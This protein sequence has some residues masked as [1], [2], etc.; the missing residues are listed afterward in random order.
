MRQTLRFFS[1]LGRQSRV[2][3]DQAELLFS[4]K[5][6]G[7]CSFYYSYFRK[8]VNKAGLLD[9]LLIMKQKYRFRRT[10]IIS[11]GL[12]AF[13]VGL[14]SSKVLEI[15]VS[16]WLLVIALIYVISFRK[17]T[18]LLLIMV[19]LLGLV[20]GFWRGNIVSNQLNEY[21]HFIGRTVSLSGKVQN[22]PVYDDKGRLDFRIDAVRINNKELIGQV[23]IKAHVNGI[24]RGDSIQASGRLSDGFGNYRASMYFANVAVAG[25]SNNLIEKFR[26][27]FFASVYSVLPEPHAS[28]GLG[29]LV[30]LRSALPKDFDNQ[31]KLVGLTHIVVA[32]GFN[33]TILVRLSRRLFEKYSKYQAF[34]GSIVLIFAFL[35]VTGASPSIVRASVVTILSLTAWYYGRRFQ[36]LLLILLGASLTAGFNPLFI[37]YDVGWWLSFL[38]FA[39][40]LILAPMI[41]NHFYGSSKPP[42]LMQ[43]AIETTAAQ[44]L[45]TPLILAMFGKVSLVALI[46][47][48]ATVPIIAFAML[49]TFVAGIAGMVFTG[50][51]AAWFALPARLILAYIIS[52]T[53]FFASPSWAQKAVNLNVVGMVL[54]YVLTI[55]AIIIFYKRTRFAFEKVPSVVE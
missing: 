40:V 52:A 53:R 37:W 20:S 1:S 26:R 43:V 10:T 46:A 7:I 27:R 8:K 39:G 22:D 25:H 36:P 54:F 13:L 44:I 28:L 23:R 47:N 41:T 32:S 49:T 48:I 6:Q 2:A 11:A 35:A 21:G 3:S 31:L 14:Y 9:I 12:G 33:L 19:I 55:L 30:G 38:A 34:T 4:L 16:F 24:R 17:H 45:A 42:L 51:I 29:F 18:I 50:G 15:H 5:L